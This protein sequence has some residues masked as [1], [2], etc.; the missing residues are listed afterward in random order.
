MVS[1]L[2]R[3]RGLDEA[4]ATALRTALEDPIFELLPLK[5]LPEQIRTCP[6][7]RGCR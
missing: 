6:P 5:N 7:A 4:S 1:L 3:K 2:G